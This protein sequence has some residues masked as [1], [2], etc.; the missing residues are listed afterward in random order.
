MNIIQTIDIYTNEPH[1]IIKYQTDKIDKPT[2]IRINLIKNNDNNY[3]TSLDIFGTNTLNKY[4]EH[5]GF[6][7]HENITDPTIP[8]E[9][10]INNISISNISKISC[11]DGFDIIDKNRIGDI[12]NNKVIIL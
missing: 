1:N 5:T 3:R 12:T 4:T 10:T 6:I 9:K 2:C 7:C 8:L 11:P